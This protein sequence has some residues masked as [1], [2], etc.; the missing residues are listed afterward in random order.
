MNKQQLIS[1]VAKQCKLPK[2]QIMTMADSMFDTIE[3]S[4]KKGQDVRLVGFG[5]WKKSKRKART[6]R[7]PQT[8]KSI[9]IPARNVVKFKAGQALLEMIN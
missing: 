4:L 6:G 1:Q 5:T 9:K 3:K 7:N 2:S 8:G